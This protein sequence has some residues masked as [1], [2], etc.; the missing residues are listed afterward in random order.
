MGD[1]VLLQHRGYVK[2]ATYFHIAG[3]KTRVRG[4][5]CRKLELSAYLSI[6]LQVVPDPVPSVIFLR[7][8]LWCSAP[9][10]PLAL[11]GP[12]SFRLR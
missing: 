3:V 12:Q 6:D 8:I 9:S 5:L 7:F 10:S 4:Q 2:S 11:T 1:R